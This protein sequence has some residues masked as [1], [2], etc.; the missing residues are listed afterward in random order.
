MKSLLVGSVFKNTEPDQIEWLKLQ[1]QF[2]ESTT[3]DFDHVSF[4]NCEEPEPFSGL[5]KVIGTGDGTIQT[6]RQHTAGLNGLA[7]PF[8]TVKDEYENFLIIDSDAFPIK[9]DWLNILR[10]SMDKNNKSIAIA[11]RPENL[12]TRLHSSIVFMKSEVIP[13]LKFNHGY[14]DSSVIG[15]DLLHMEELDVGI[16]DFQEE[17][18]DQVFPLIRTNKINVHPISCGVYF[19]MF[20]HHAFGSPTSSTQFRIDIRGYNHYSDNDFPDLHERIRSDPFTFVRRLAGW[21]PQQ[22]P[23]KP[24]QCKGETGA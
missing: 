1:L 11:L 6:G 5:T 23:G 3:E 10:T 24:D 7:N 2:L 17:K 12:E 19:D 8:R 16:A 9:L 18:R 13:E 22:Y 4:I 21:C 15:R 20:Y 14:E